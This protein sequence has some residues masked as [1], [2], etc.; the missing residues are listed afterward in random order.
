MIV[1][2]SPRERGDDPEEVWEEMAADRD[3]LIAL[4]IEPEMSAAQDPAAPAEDEDEDE[5]E[6]ADAMD[7]R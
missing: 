6:D 5:D 4:G 3:K 2:H 7:G 1:P